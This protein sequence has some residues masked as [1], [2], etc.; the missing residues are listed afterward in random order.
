M[1]DGMIQ[2]GWPEIWTVYITTWAVLLAY[3]VSIYLRGRQSS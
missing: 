3:G 2:G 1:T